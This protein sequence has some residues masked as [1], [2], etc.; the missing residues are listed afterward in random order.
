MNHFVHRELLDVWRPLQFNTRRCHTFREALRDPGMPSIELLVADDGDPALVIAR[1][2]A[3]D[4]A[5][6]DL[7]VL[8]LALPR[9]NGFEILRE[10]RADPV[11]SATPVCILTYSDDETHVRTAYELGANCF[12]VKPPTFRP[13]LQGSRAT[14]FAR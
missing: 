5:G 13:M 2:A 14:N 6:L 11:L 7:I 8:D 1:Q 12:V 4:H 10:I 3:G 9:R